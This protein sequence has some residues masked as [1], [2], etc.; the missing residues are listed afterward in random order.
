MLICIACIG[1]AL[2][3]LAADRPTPMAP[4]LA[5]L[6][7]GADATGKPNYASPFGRGYL[8]PSF[9]IPLT[10]SAG[11]A[12]QQTFPARFDWRDQGVVT[13]LQDQGACG[14]CWAFATLASWESK[15]LR[16]GQGLWD[17][18][19]NNV[20]E[21]LWAAVYQGFNGCIGGNFWMAAS[22]LALKGAVTEACDPYNAANQ[23]CNGSCSP[24]LTLTNGDVLAGSQTPSVAQLK[25]WLTQYG[26]L[27]ITVNSGSREPLWGAEFDAY[28]G[29][30]TLYHPIPTPDQND[31]AV[32]LVGWDDALAH[33]GG[34]GAWIVKN[35]WGTDWGGT[36]GFGTQRGYFTIA[37]GSAGTGRDAAV[38]TDWRVP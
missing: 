33:A 22:H 5:P 6:R 18:S 26:P 29:S 7:H 35:S 13:N 12:P 19:E 34:Q 17:L 16:S 9:D 37:W 1:S 14:S 21:C 25:A 31:H 4:S 2:P 3:G 32:L 38:V 36:G 8:A 30:Y 10:A 24:V 27:Y 20:A 15:L 23:L 28:D 11:V